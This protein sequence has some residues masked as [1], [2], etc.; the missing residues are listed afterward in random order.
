M[1]RLRAASERE[2]AC[3]E[4]RA[5]APGRVLV[6]DTEDTGTED[7]GTKGGGT[8]DAGPRSPALSPAAWSAFLDGIDPAGTGPRVSA[9]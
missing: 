3:A 5:E 6:R 2:E 8:K 4:V 7:T 1:R 9:S